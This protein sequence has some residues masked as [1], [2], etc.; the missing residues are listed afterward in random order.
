[1]ERQLPSDGGIRRV[2]A[3]NSQF[4]HVS[5]GRVQVEHVVVATPDLRCACS[6]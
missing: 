1:M 2:G 5:R 3:P 4:A 6:P